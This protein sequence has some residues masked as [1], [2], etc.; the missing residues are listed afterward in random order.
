VCVDVV[1]VWR[2]DNGGAFWR[3]CLMK[4]FHTIGATAIAVSP[5]NHDVLLCTSQVSW[6]TSRADQEGLYRSTDGGDN[7]TRVVSAA[8]N[9]SGT[10][11]LPTISFAANGT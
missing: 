5:T 2:S 10:V 6:D 9:E 4:G 3:P 8:N 1:H 11:N 7:W